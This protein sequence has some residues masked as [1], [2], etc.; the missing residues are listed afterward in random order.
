[1]RH[2]PLT[3]FSFA[4]A[5]AVVVFTGGS[6]S[7]QAPN[8][9]KKQTAI[10][11]MPDGKPDLQGAWDFRTITPMERPTNL[12]GKEVLSDQEAAEFET[13]NQRNQDDRTAVSRGVSNGAPTNTD[14]ERAYNDFW[15]DFGKKIVSTKRT[16]LVI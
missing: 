15:W 9:A 6:L 4:V 5:I 13:K 14:L 16:S 2:R 10:P 8:G 7:G 12:A 11:R 1:M 3:I